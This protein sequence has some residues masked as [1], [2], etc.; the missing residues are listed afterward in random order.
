[1]R[2]YYASNEEDQSDYSKSLGNSTEAILIDKA[3]LSSSDSHVVVDPKPTHLN[4]VENLSSVVN[5]EIP[6]IMKER[7]DIQ[8]KTTNISFTGNHANDSGS[9]VIIVN[10]GGIVNNIS[11]SSAFKDEIN[12][13]ENGYLNHQKWNSQDGNTENVTSM[14]KNLSKTKKKDSSSTTHSA[15]RFKLLLIFGACCIIG[16]YLIPIAVYGIQSGGNDIDD[17]YSSEQNI[18][19][20][21][22]CYV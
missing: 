10:S 20:A 11:D 8:H 13:T 21:N 15:W 19:S 4:A 1:M 17:D 7:E 14:P 16:C 12:K 9:H 18:S 5:I 3:S 22:V 6:V 2:S